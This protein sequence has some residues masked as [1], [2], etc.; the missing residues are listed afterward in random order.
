MALFT[1]SPTPAACT[2]RLSNVLR[3]VEDIQDLLDATS[4][5]KDYKGD[6]DANRKHALRHLKEAQSAIEAAWNGIL[7]GRHRPT[8]DDEIA[9]TGEMQAKYLVILRAEVKRMQAESLHA[10]EDLTTLRA[11]V[12]WLEAEWLDAEKRAAAAEALASQQ[13]G[14]ETA[15]RVRRLVMSEA[16]P[17]KATNAAELE[18]RTRLCQTLFPQIDRIMSGE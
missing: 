7:V 9:N 17:D 2:T 12:K 4:K 18:W 6:W 10:E 11:E 8:L 5:G 13:G 16:H 15:R 3:E 14:E 1:K